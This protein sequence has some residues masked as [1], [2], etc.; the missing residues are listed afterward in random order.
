MA[1]L[2]V[3]EVAHDPELAA[4]LGESLLRLVCLLARGGRGPSGQRRGEEGLFEGRS[5]ACFAAAWASAWR[6]ASA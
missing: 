4:L 2:E 6:T 1:R 3:E 5:P